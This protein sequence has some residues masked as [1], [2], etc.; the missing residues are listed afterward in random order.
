M[1]TID[2]FNALKKL[3]YPITNSERQTENGDV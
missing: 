2:Y 1:Q 3:Y